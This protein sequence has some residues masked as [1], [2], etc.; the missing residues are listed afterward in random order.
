MPAQNRKLTENV[1]WEQDEPL[2]FKTDFSPGIWLNLQFV[3][4]WRFLW[5]A[6]LWSWKGLNVKGPII[7]YFAITVL[8]PRR[9]LRETAGPEFIVRADIKLHMDGYQTILMINTFVIFQWW[10]TDLDYSRQH[11]NNIVNKIHGRALPVPNKDSCSCFEFTLE[12]NNSVF[13]HQQLPV[14]VD[15][16][17]GKSQ[18]RGAKLN[19]RFRKK[20]FEQ[21]T[22]GVLFSYQKPEQ[23]STESNLHYFYSCIT[24]KYVAI[25]L[26]RKYKDLEEKKLL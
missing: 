6:F 4:T 14:A 1:N 15:S 24:W 17:L 26:A 20:V 11:I 2:L 9:F 12:R 22:E 23:Q 25:Y 5:W 7:S 3:I 19:P 21:S 13:Y 10:S 16:K 18:N 8:S